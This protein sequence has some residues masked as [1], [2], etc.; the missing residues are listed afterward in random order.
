MSIVLEKG[1][2]INLSKGNKN[3]GKINVNLNWNTGSKKEYCHH[4]LV[5]NLNLLI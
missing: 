5:L 2:K 1:S 3:L 4:Y